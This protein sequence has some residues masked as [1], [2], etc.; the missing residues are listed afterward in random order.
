MRHTIEKT[1][2]QTHRNNGNPN[3][4]LF[5]V[6]MVVRVEQTR[7]LYPKSV[8]Y[9]FAYTLCSFVVCGDAGW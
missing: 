5:L 7:E 9:F 2:I 1:V 8:E 3:S 6:H 4:S